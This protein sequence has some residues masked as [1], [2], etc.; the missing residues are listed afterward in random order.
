MRVARF[1]SCVIRVRRTLEEAELAV[2]LYRDFKSDP[3]IL[4]AFLPSENKRPVRLV[5]TES[6]AHRTILPTCCCVGF[7][8]P[9]EAS[10]RGS[11]L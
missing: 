6:H 2:K 3:T 1:G 11:V 8:R 4:Q 9:L 7:A 5:Q 10:L